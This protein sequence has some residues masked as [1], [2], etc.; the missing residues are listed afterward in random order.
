MHLK[1]SSAK[2]RPF[3]PGL[4]VLRIVSDMAIAGVNM[5]VLYGDD[6]VTFCWS[7]ATIEF[8]CQSWEV[9][10]RN[11]ASMIDIFWQ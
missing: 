5:P 8:A 2:W 9:I 4:N 10:D 11:K 1:L 3:C 7:A 6:E